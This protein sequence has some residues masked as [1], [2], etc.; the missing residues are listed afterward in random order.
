MD[1][2]SLHPIFI[3]IPAWD[4]HSLPADLCGACRIAPL[5]RRMIR[6]FRELSQRRSPQA[7][8]YGNSA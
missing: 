3:E 5:D 7:L 2:V 4:L 8:Q 1:H 6:L